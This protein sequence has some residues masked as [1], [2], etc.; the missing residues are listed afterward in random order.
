MTDAAVSLREWA[1]DLEAA[2]GIARAIVGTPFVPDQLRIWINPAERDP[3]K[4]MLDVDQT[5]A[6]VSAVLLAGQELALPP[7]ASLR[8]FTVIRG[9]VAMYAVAARAL[10][11]SHGHEII[12]REST[13]TRAIVDGRRAGAEQW[14]RSIWDI[15]RAKIA[16]LYPGHPDGNWAQAA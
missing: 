12:I 9:T 16:K 10:L 2:A 1:I 5:V 15:D 8:A 3:A 7:M 13:S 4:K 14:Q 11:L 6:T